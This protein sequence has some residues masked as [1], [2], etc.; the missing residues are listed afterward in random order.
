MQQQ[1]PSVTWTL[2]GHAGFVPSGHPLGDAAP[3]AVRGCSVTQAAKPSSKRQNA[4][5]NQ[6]CDQALTHYA[7]MVQQQTSPLTS[8][9]RSMKNSACAQRSEQDS[10]P[11]ACK[12]PL[13]IQFVGGSE[14]LGSSTSAGAQKPRQ[15]QEPAL[16]LTAACC[17][18]STQGQ[19]QSSLVSFSCQV[20]GYDS[21]NHPKE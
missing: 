11:A 17:Y 7:V 16:F 14:Q 8:Y 4:A 9:W 2:V 15:K 13:H 19:E 1:E 18:Q 6:S 5:G 20:D 12:K 10:S 21:F 3:K